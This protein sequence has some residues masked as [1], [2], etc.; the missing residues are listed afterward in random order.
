[1]KRATTIML[2]V[3]LTSVWTAE[4]SAGWLG[5]RTAD[6]D[7]RQ[8][9]VHRFPGTVQRFLQA[10]VLRDGGGDRWL[11]DDTELVLPFDSLVLDERGRRGFLQSGRQV[12]VLGAW[13][14]DAV[15]ARVVRFRPERGYDAAVERE[16]YG[17]QWSEVNPD[18]GQGLT[19]G[20]E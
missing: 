12:L 19:I 6:N 5:C 11:L 20:V 9:L 13:Y 17:I 7:A 16:R 18:V 2:A 14:G 15:V 3:L 1:M 4:A 10:G 8:P